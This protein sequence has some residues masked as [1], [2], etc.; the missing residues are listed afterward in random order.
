MKRGLV[1]ISLSLIA[2]CAAPAA[3]PAAAAP[4][5]PPPRN[6]LG[7]ELFNGRALL[8]DLPIYWR[9][10]KNQNGAVDPD[11]LASLLFYPAGPA[12]VDKG[13][14]TAAFDRALAAMI[15]YPTERERAHAKLDAAER[16]RRLLVED[17]LNQGRTTLVATDLGKL[18][19]D[20]RAFIGKMQDVAAAV[21]AL[22]AVQ[23]GL[24]AL[25]AKVPADDVASR[26][27]FRRNWGTRCEGPR[28]ERN[29]KCAAVPGGPIRLVDLY[30]AEL[31]KDAK[32]CE[33][34]EKHPDSKALLAPFVVVRSE[35]GKLVPVGYHLAYTAQMKR[36]SDALIAA[37]APLPESEAPLKRYLAAAAEA[38]KTNDW[39]AADEAWAA[40][41]AR[42]SKW[43]V[44]VGPDETYWEPC[45]QKA[46]FHMTFALINRDSLAWQDKLTP[47]QQEMENAIGTLVGKAYAPRKV[48][49]HLPDF[50]DIVWNS[51]DDRKAFG[52]TIGQS[53]PNW[54]KVA[55]EG[56]GRTVA[57]SNLYEDPDS[58][59]MRKLQAASLLSKETMTS[60]TTEA[61]AG[62]LSTILHEAT[63]NLGPAHE[64]AVNGVTNA[65]GFGGGLASMLE[66][67]KAQSGAL[68][69]LD[70][71][72]G[73]KII[74][75]ELRNQSYTDSIVWAFGHISRGMWTESGGRKAYSQLAA[76]QVGFL[77]DEGALLYAPDQLAANGTDKGAFTVVHD[78]L[79]AAT[80]KLMKLVATIK[81]T[82]DKAGA[83]ALA[84]KYI[85]G[86]RLPHAQITE[87]FLRFPKATFV[88][89][90]DGARAP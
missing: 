15:A 85:E 32:F 40:M 44:R 11:E 14:F 54:G 55:N 83:E 61:I 88:Y 19:A 78:K 59:S 34:L 27:L 38:F 8:L 89:A 71:L 9:A 87:R 26:S 57:M 90:L 80:T 58:R 3:K 6:A 53:L 50:I 68:Y 74:T 82:N 51:G 16:E 4:S 29:P 65:Q 21:D 18:S 24:P 23:S 48:S 67:L 1:A 46:G 30:P 31:Q 64:Y 35:G 62:L 5:Q 60:Y 73:K 37:A 2:G 76:I 22:Y 13:Q 49:F 70:Y 43:F 12:Y 36:T 52:A 33:P 66:E 72:V 56:R 17:E 39:L 63:H 81:A 41:N 7:R 77:L 28:T 86:P 25:A 75:A 47:L 84:K 45:A 42:N 10:D 69:Y 20:E 79:P